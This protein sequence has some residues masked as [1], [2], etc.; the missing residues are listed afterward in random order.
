[1]TEQ[2]LDIINIKLAEEAKNLMTDRFP[3]MVS[4]F[5]E[6]TQMYLEEIEKGATEDDPER[7]I[8]PAHTIK[9]SAKQLGAERV[10]E[11]AK[12]IEELCRNLVENGSNDLEQFKNL[13]KQLKEEIELATPELNKLCE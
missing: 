2:Q 7:A 11:I 13:S 5:L 12:N 9:S 8:S 4:Y 1:M 10:S 3:T 6:D